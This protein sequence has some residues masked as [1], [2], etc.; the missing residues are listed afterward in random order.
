M[1]HGL[2]RELLG[3][4]LWLLKEC[5][6]KMVSSGRWSLH[7]E[8]WVAGKQL[9]SLWKETSVTLGRTRNATKRAIPELQELKQGLKRKNIFMEVMQIHL[10]VEWRKQGMGLMV[11]K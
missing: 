2:G 7:G 4:K 3:G 9:K 11:R 5:M 10:W 1:D 8:G 6:M